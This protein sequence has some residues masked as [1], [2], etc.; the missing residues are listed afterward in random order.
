MK[1]RQKPIYSAVKDL[2][3][4]GPPKQEAPAPPRP[5]LVPG[6]GISPNKPAGAEPASVSALDRATSASRS[7]SMICFAN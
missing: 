3:I 1:R 4:S 6:N 5:E 2:D 7:F